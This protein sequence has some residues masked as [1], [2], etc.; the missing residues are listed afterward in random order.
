MKEVFGAEYSVFS[1]VIVIIA[2]VLL[3]VSGKAV[4]TNA[5]APCFR[6]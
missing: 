3:A 2:L 6:R 4:P 1:K 5:P